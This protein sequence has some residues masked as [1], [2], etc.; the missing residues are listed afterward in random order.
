MVGRWSW[1]LAA[2]LFAGAAGPALA[3]QQQPAADKVT[4]EVNRLTQGQ[5][6]CQVFMIA[7]NATPRDFGSLQADLVTF[8]ADGVVN[9]RLLVELA[10]LN[11][12][13]TVLRP[14][15]IPEVAC[16]GIDR[17][18]LNEVPRCEDA[19]GGAVQ[20]C[21]ALVEPASRAKAAFFK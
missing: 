1:V 15:E 9:G 10:P 20:G 13:K 14:F 17:V 11:A 8:G 5:G 3:Q 21:T 12:G 18:L 6:G 19:S 2:A 4:V 7:R 16:D